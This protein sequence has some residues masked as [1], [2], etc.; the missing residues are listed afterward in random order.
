[1]SLHLI[2]MP[3]SLPSLNRWAGQRNLGRNQ[4]D[5]GLALH[6]LLGEA[7]G[8]AVLQPFRLL[9]A[10][11]A[12]TGTLYAYS[13][14]S[15]EELRASAAPVLGPSEAEVVSLDALRSIERPENTWKMGARLGFD[16]KSRP[17][18]RLASAIESAD[19]RF[20]K[21]AEVDVFLAKT[22]RNDEARPR[23][24][25]YL[26]WLAARVSPAAELV[27][28]ECRLHQF[29]RVRSLRG[30]HRVEGPEAVIHGTLVVHEPQEFSRLL[31]RG[32]GRH[33]SY[34]YGMLLL[35][36]PQRRG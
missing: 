17:V 8:P 21:G 29:R 5:E 9:V 19:G 18:V 12:R 33:R 32:V 30:G 27:R 1:M 36:P 3:L 6:H 34:G 7:F 15:A 23:E 4:F 11:R 10:S 13:A 25:V 35:R 22:L 31:A 26:D 14:A 24:D 2:E 28:D 20:Q 16:L